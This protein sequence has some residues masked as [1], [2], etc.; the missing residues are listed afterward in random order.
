MHRRLIQS[1]A[2]V[3]GA[4]AIVAAPLVFATAAHADANPNVTICHA[5]GNPDKFVVITID[6]AAITKKGH[7]THQN[8]NDVIPPFEYVAENTQKTVSFPGQNWDDNWETNGEGV[9][10]GEVDPADCG[11]PTHETPSTP[12]TPSSPTR[13]VVETDRVDTGSGANLGL[14]AGVTV[15]G[16]GVGAVLVGRRRE[17]SHR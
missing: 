3:A 12:S 8:D 4:A 1:S 13:P 16:A 9:A 2:S 17:G 14:L 10:S 11:Q 5:T 6:A 7:D 15:V